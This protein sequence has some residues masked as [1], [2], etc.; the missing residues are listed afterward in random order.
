MSNYLSAA[1]TGRSLLVAD[2]HGVDAASQAGNNQPEEGQSGVTGGKEEVVANADAEES[3]ADDE[4][5]VGREESGEKPDTEDGD[6]EPE[7]EVEEER[8]TAT[9]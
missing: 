3:G 7:M 1:L 2:P 5:P 4:K 6:E 9:G 8:K